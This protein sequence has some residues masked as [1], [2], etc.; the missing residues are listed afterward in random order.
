MK[1]VNNEYAEPLINLINVIKKYYPITVDK[2]ATK[3]IGLIIQWDYKNRKA[4]IHMPGYLQKALIRFKHKTSD[5]IQNSP[6]PH[7][8][9][10]YGAKTQ[11][12]TEEDV[13]PP[14]S[15]EET[16]YVQVVAGTLLYYARVVNTT[17]LMALSLIAIEQANLTQETMSRVK[18][19]LDYCA[20]QEDAI[21]TYNASKMI[22]AIHSNAGYCNKKERTQP[23]RR[24][25]FLIK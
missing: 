23:S 9:P 16:E 13:S 10:Q 18:Q 11:S 15:K 17:I 24:T 22:L 1:Y 12:T 2:E 21:I 3:Y 7:V 25:F 6:H 5:K 20:T 19:L 4:H 8:I 14:L